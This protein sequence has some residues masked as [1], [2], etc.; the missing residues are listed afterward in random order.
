MVFIDNQRKRKKAYHETSF[1]IA[2]RL[3]VFHKGILRQYGTC[4][5]EYRL[6]FIHQW[7]YKSFSWLKGKFYRVAIRPAMLYGTKY[8]LVKKTFKHKT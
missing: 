3:E 1:V 4:M 5:T 6:T 8:L 7:G 2:T